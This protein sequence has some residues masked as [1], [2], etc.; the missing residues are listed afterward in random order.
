L[1]LW[2]TKFLW[3]RWSWTRCS[4]HNLSCNWK[5]KNNLNYDVVYELSYIL[6]SFK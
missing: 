4:Q 3:Y 1:D 6:A 5:G 2:H